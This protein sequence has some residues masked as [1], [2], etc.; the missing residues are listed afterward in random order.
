MTDILYTYKNKV[1]V[2]LT[3]SCSCRCVFCV[4]NEGKNIGEAENL[5]FE[6]TPKLE[7]IKEAIDKFDFSD[8]DELIYCGYGEPTC[9]IDNL[10]QSAKYFKSNHKQKIRVNTNG[11]G[12]LY[13]NRS[14]LPEL[15]D[16]VD[17]FS[18][19]LNAP[20]SERYNELCRPLFENAF[21]EM[22]SFAKVC[23]QLGKEVV[24]SVVSI[25]SADEIEQCRKL[26]ESM[27]IPL[28]VRIYSKN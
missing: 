3:N 17:A 13:N 26:S 28:K 20:N 25:I 4:R 14:I 6:K 18:I 12:N 22:L 2:N 21:K 16:V 24:F 10:I 11:L 8:Y 1:Y 19:S 7:E 15:A 9:E 23:K 5:F 27:N